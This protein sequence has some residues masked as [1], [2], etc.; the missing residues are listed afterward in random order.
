M[1]TPTIEDLKWCSDAVIGRRKGSLLLKN[2]RVA[3]VFTLD[4]ESASVLVAGQLI[5]GVGQDFTDADAETIVDLAGAI[6]TPGLIDGH[7]HI[8]SSLVT[9]AEYEAAVLRRGVTGIVADPHEV[10]NVAG[11]AA[12]EWMIQA[13]E[14]LQM[15]IWFAVPSSVPAT[16]METSGAVL[17]VED[18]DRLLQH[19]QVVAIGE[20]MNVPGFVGGDSQELEKSMLTHDKPHTA[21]GHAPGLVGRPLQ[22]YLA[23]GISSDHESTT[24][25]EGM[26]KLKA[27]CFLMIR[28]GSAT[29]NLEA[30]M[31]LLNPRYGDRIG[32]V[33]D[34]RLPHDLLHEGGVDFVVR[35]AISLGADPI[36][37]IRCA[38]WNTARH[39]RLQ[40]RG[41]IAPGYFADM[42]VCDRF[43]GFTAT[44]VIKDGEYVSSEAIALEA[45]DVPESIRNTVKL[46]K[47]ELSDLQIA[48]KRGSIRV[49]EAIPNQILTREKIVEPTIHGDLAIAD[50]DKDL[51][52]LICVERHGH[53][54]KIAKGFT[55][56]FGL[57]EGAL[58]CSVAHDH[59]NCL[60]VGMNDEDILMALQRL[61]TLGGGLVVVNHGQV[62][63]ELSL[64]IFG[65]LSD[66]PLEQVRVALVEIDLAAKSLGCTLPS[67]IMA[68]SFLG[69]EVIPELRLTDLGLVDV[70]E[71]KFVDLWV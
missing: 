35:K 57:R 66:Q 45:D 9:P 56:G 67:Q 6:L 47:L 69:L 51:A 61:Q 19:P 60:A 64:P 7:L 41:A 39:F 11:V 62:L 3:N 12:I 58:A 13:S 40:R 34:D 18:I 2:A 29:R 8:E 68:L 16:P 37:A 63:A 24:L 32:L 27:G 38:S 50:P 53:H 26:Q 49:I 31:P 36:Y 33:T 1:K 17:T 23:A 55:S 65:L 52:K 44:S 15:D 46:P 25:D 22:A 71:G 28:E 70:V 42:V 14:R 54:G 30:L 4:L 21:E 43:E 5:A 10:A 59:H 48:A 20:L